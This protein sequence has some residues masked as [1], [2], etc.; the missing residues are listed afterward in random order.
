M[1]YLTDIEIAK[2]CKEGKLPSCDKCPVKM[3]DK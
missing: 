2:Q 1:A 3:N